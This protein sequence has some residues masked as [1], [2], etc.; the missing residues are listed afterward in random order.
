MCI[1]NRFNEKLKD[2]FIMIYNI[3]YDKNFSNDF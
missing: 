3:L 1:R 2:N